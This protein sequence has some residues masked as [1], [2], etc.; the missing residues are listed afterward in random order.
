LN[1]DYRFN[2][3]EVKRDTYS[4]LCGYS[5]STTEAFAT[6]FGIGFI[7]LENAVWEQRS[8]K[9]GD[10]VT[11]FVSDKGELII[12]GSGKMNLR[13][14]NSRTNIIPWVEYYDEIT[15][16]I[17]QDGITDICNGSF[18]GCFNAKSIII[19]ESVT[20]IGDSAFYGCRSLTSIT[21]PNGVTSIGSYAFCG[22]RSLTSI[23]IPNGVTS[24]GHAAFSSCD[25]LTSITIP[26]SVTS[27]GTYAF[28]GCRSL[29]SITI[30]DGVTSIGGSAFFYCDNLTSITIP[31]SVTSIGHAA[32]SSCDSL[33]SIT[34]PDSVTSIGDSA[35]YGCRSLTSIT[36]PNGVTSIGS[37]AFCGCR[38]LTSITIPDSVTSIGY[39]AFSNWK[40]VTIYCYSGSYAE[41]YAKEH[42]I[43][44]VIIEKP[45]P[46]IASG[47]CGENL[48]WKLSESGKLTISGTG[49]MYDY[50]FGETPWHNYI[51]NIKVIVIEE[52]VTTIGACA[53]CGC[54][55]LYGITLPSTI[56]SI[57]Y[58]A[59]SGCTG[60]TGFTVPANVTSI[61]DNAFFG[62]INITVIHLYPGVVYIGSHAFDGCTKLR[63]IDLPD[64]ITYIGD[65][66]FNGCTGLTKIIVPIGVTEL[67]PYVFN[68][69]INITVIIIH[70]KVTLIDANAFCGCKCHIHGYNNSYV[71]EYAQ[72]YNYVFVPL[73]FIWTDNS[74]WGTPE[75]KKADELKIFPD[76]LKEKDLASNI[77]RAEFAAICVKACEKLTGT[78]LLPAITDPFTDTDDIEV[79][80]AYNAGITTGVSE[81]EFAPNALLTREQA[82]TMLTR[83]FKK[84]TIPG[85][86]VASDKDHPL[87][88]TVPPMFSD[89][90]NIS[91]WAKESVYFMAANG[92]INGMGDN[93]FAP[94]NTTTEEEAA[95]YANATREQALIIAV[96][97]I[98]NLSAK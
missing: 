74:E 27:I 4:I 91:D 45:E 18:S 5:G 8:G 23:T 71:Q 3:N 96:R 24:I 65:Y 29:T 73:L 40:K 17:I 87:K 70:S 69:C 52:G 39:E 13:N 59:F 33:T 6:K 56:T 86:S 98:T 11:W 15:S 14:I 36:I 72:K 20:S 26:D 66:A 42:N 55:S 88:Y 62:C 47:N 63:E 58:G 76:T 85:W 92:I 43:K 48:T 81:T 46:L 12:S 34:I 93:K 97:M 95:G 30:P 7:P 54:S 80:K 25:S 90:A 64:T 31:D 19:P 37:H 51:V 28:Y 89:D 16:I 9:C 84:A 32:F 2:G 1:K 61:G 21:I 77:T 78:A 49:V 44:Y 94:K 38:S 75:L 57:G 82:A 79:L 83:V 68:G 50:S 22:C 10:N 35:F 60:L 53:F 41:Q 67:R